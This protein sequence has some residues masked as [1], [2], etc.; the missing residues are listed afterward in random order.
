MDT[1]AWLVVLG[2]AAIAGVAITALVKSINNSDDIDN[3]QRR[4]ASPS[5]P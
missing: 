2:G 4:I 1:G 3:I 5:R